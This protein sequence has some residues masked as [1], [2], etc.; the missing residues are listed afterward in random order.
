NS[1]FE[2]TLIDINETYGKRIHTVKKNLYEEGLK[3]ICISYRWGELEEWYEQTVDYLAHITSFDKTD[4]LLLCDCIQREP[5]LK[6]I[7]YLWIDAICVNQVNKEER[8]ATIRKMSEIY[9]IAMYILAVPD[10]NY[11]YLKNDPTYLKHIYNIGRY[12]R[13]FYQEITDENRLEVY[14]LDA[15][16]IVT[17]V[18]QY[19]DPKLHGN[20]NFQQ[21]LNQFIKMKDELIIPH[22]PETDSFYHKEL[23][24]ALEMV[25]QEKDE[26]KWYTQYYYNNFEYNHIPVTSNRS[27]KEWELYYKRI[28]QQFNSHIKNLKQVFIELMMKDLEYKQMKKDTLDYF[29]GV[30]T[31]WRNRTWVISEYNFAKQKKNK[32]PMKLIFIALLANLQFEEDKKYYPFYDIFNYEKQ[33][34]LGS[35]IKQ[36][37]DSLSTS[38]PLD[39]ILN[40]KTKDNEDRFHVILPLWGKYNSIIKN[41]DTISS[42]KISDMISVRLK[43]YEFLDIEDKRRLLHASSNERQKYPS[44]AIDYFKEWYFVE[45]IHYNKYQERNDL[46]ILPELEFILIYHQQ[47]Q[48]IIYKV[49]LTIPNEK[50]TENIHKIQLLPTN[51]YLE[52]NCDIYYKVAPMEDIFNENEMVV[53]PFYRLEIIN[54]NKN[55]VPSNC[56]LPLLRKKNEIHWEIY[57]YTTSIRS[58]G[59][60]IFHKTSFYVSNDAMKQDGIFTIK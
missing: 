10:M 52:I 4:L 55:S 59:R 35:I 24:Y 57:R 39:M 30:I 46:A 31:A 36:I 33:Y 23:I 60:H 44:F 42:W 37:E 45:D 12:A 26:N 50:Y 2:I 51:R 18:L 32:T 14:D 16:L 43:L 27:S 6:D 17:W 5:D 13:H 22:I 20:F 29:F 25:V 15:Q 28:G 7:N 53:V 19:I 40:S 58:R 1:Y 48:K 3:Y 41:K 21:L 54:D 11:S 56:F 47:S 34:H 38:D 8:K 49:D 9:Q